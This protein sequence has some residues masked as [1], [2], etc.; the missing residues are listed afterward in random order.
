MAKLPSAVGTSREPV[1]HPSLYGGNRYCWKYLFKETSIMRKRPTNCQREEIRQAANLRLGATTRG[2]FH[3]GVCAEYHPQSRLM[4]L[5]Y[6]DLILRLTKL[7]LERP[8]LFPESDAIPYRDSRPTVRRAPAPCMQQSLGASRR[9]PQLSIGCRQASRTPPPWSDRTRIR[10]GFL[11]WP[12][13]S[14]KGTTNGLRE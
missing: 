12:I 14:V 4:Y 6:V 2:D 8:D 11:T 13:R 7:S 5:Q 10:P 9:A 3:F 1:H